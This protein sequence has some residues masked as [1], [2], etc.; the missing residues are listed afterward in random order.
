MVLMFIGCFYPGRGVIR[1]NQVSLSS[2]SSSFLTDPPIFIL[3]GDTSGGPPENYAWTRGGMEITNNASFNISI[4][5][6]ED[7]NPARFSDSLYM[8]TLTVTGRYPG[9][10][11]YTVSNR[12]TISNLTDNFIIEGMCMWKPKVALH[13]QGHTN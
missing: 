3:V 9:E 5:V 13:A 8:S 2:S 11:A 10:Y 12:V 1:S 7:A 6:K 4:S